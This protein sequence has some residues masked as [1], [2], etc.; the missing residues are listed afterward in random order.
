M[1]TRKGTI[2]FLDQ[3][4]KVS[5]NIIHEQMQK[6]EDKYAAVENPEMSLE[7]GITVAKI[8]NMAVLDS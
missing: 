6:N 1:S 4:I 3:L 8:Q 2:A 5:G 7:I